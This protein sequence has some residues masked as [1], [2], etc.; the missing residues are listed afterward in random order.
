MTPR[1]ATMRMEIGIVSQNA[2]VPAASSVNMIASVA[3]ATDDRL[4][5]EKTASAFGIDRR[6]SASSPLA[7]GR[8]NR[9]RRVLAAACPSGW[10]GALAAGRAVTL[11]GPAYRK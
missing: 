11:P 1:T 2:A 8:P 9:I 10:I 5:L 6:S 4:S 3:Y 7:S